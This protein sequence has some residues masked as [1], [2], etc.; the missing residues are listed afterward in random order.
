M[1]ILRSILGV[2]LV[3]MLSQRYKANELDPGSAWAAV[4]LIKLDQ[5]SL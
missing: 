3:I 1:R 5:V 4:T 2:L